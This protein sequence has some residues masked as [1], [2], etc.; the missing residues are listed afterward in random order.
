LQDP[1][2]MRTVTLPLPMLGFIVSTRAALAAGLGLL[3]ADRIPRERRRKAGLAL[4]VIGAVTTL[5]ALSFVTRGFRRRP[6]RPRVD[7]DRGLVGATRH[8]RKGNDPW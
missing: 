1:I 7:V 4:A 3:L 5:P 8:P 2:S 6:S